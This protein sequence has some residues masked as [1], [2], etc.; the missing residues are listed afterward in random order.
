MTDLRQK[1]DGS[2]RSS[3]AVTKQARLAVYC[4]SGRPM[5]QLEGTAFP[6]D[7]D[8]RQEISAVFSGLHPKP[9]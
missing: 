6:W 9:L 1:R 8:P 5:R 2:G 7:I 4:S 3:A